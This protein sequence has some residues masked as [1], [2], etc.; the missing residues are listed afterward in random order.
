[1]TWTA[2]L[3]ICD[4]VLEAEALA[5]GLAEAERLCAY[6]CERDM[7]ISSVSSDLYALSADG[8]VMVT[9]DHHTA[10]EGLRIDLRDVNTTSR[11]LADLNSAGVEL[12]LF[13]TDAD[14]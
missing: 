8:H 3:G 13:Y 11:L 5:F 1:L 10:A 12:E 4:V 6:L 2:S 14:K 9:W 7:S